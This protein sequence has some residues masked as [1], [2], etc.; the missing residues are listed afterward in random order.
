MQIE[1]GAGVDVAADVRVQA[2][3]RL[4]LP[5]AYNTQLGANAH[6]QNTQ[7]TQNPK[8]TGIASG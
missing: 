7:N 3:A 5:P 6:T 4:H 1:G 8:C 2:E